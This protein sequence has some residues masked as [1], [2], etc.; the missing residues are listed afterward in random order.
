MKKFVISLMIFLIS[1]TLLG[2]AEKGTISIRPWIGGTS[3]SMSKFNKYLDSTGFQN[4]KTNSAFILGI[5]GAYTITDN[6]S[7]GPRIEYINVDQ[8]NYKD[9]SLNCLY[10]YNFSLVPVMFGLNYTKNI[11]DELNFLSSLY[12]GYGFARLE[13][14]IQD[15]DMQYDS[16][17]ET[18]EGFCS[19]IEMNIGGEYIVSELLSFGFNL[20]YRIAEVKKIKYTDSWN[21]LVDDNGSEI[22]LD[23]SGFVVAFNLDYQF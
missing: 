18:L 15:I 2:A 6:V 23:F 17:G 13:E 16:V 5:D 22:E 11:N 19:I 8:A 9:T 14:I 12:I 21:F 20:G 10:M 3:I 1:A 4:K 7:I